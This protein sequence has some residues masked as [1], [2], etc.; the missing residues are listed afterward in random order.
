VPIAIGHALAVGIV[1]MIAVLLGLTLPLALI[2]WL[3]A[4]MLVALGILYLLRQPRA[5]YRLVI[6]C[7]QL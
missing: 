3:V 5:R 4:A 1:V 6:I 7:R 2:R